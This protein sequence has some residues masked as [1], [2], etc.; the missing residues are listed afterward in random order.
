MPEA[1][2]NVETNQF[3]YFVTVSVENLEE[4]P[5]GFRE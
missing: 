5:G 1:T 4:I 2:L 3:T